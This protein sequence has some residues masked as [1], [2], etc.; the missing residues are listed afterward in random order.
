MTCS[1]SSHIPLCTV[2]THI[3]GL[4]TE[5][6]LHFEVLG[7]LNWQ[8]THFGLCC[9]SEDLLLFKIHEDGKKRTVPLARGICELDK[10]TVAL[11]MQVP[12]TKVPCKSPGDW[13]YPGMNEFPPQ[14]C[15][16]RRSRRQHFCRCAV[17]VS[18]LG[19]LRALGYSGLLQMECSRPSHFASYLVIQGT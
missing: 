4:S 17:Q 8:P 13:V 7:N 14:F 19:L 12:L 11:L 10:H 3:L 16:P 15:I 5:N 18:S 9:D 2:L 1:F 6:K